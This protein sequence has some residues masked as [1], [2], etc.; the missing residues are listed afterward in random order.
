MGLERPGAAVQDAT[1]AFGR[2]RAAS[3]D[4]TMALLLL[5]ATV[6][7][8][9]SCQGHDL[10]VQ[11][12]DPTAH[13]EVVAIRNAGRRRDWEQL[14]LVSTLSPCI[15]CTGASLL[16]KIKRVV[17]GENINFSSFAE[18]VMASQGVEVHLIQDSSCIEMMESF[19]KEKNDLWQED[20]H[21]I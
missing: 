10:R 6:A 19:I 11:N 18:G 21:D 1:G 8:L 5:V 9:A 12:G 20:I 3:H 2:A 15:M 17:V 16:Y 14:T 4:A 7:L 13:A